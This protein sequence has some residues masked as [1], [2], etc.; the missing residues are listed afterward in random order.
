MYRIELFLRMHGWSLTKKYRKSKTLVYTKDN[1]SNEVIL[2]PKHKPT[3]AWEIRVGYPYE[4]CIS[5]NWDKLEPKFIE[6]SKQ[7]LE[8]HLNDSMDF[9]NKLRAIENPWE[10]I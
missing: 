6:N 7:F 10:K 1:S 3:P 8:Q 2:F 4:L 9:N 5:Y